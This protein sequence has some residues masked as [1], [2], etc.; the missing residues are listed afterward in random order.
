M[1]AFTVPVTWSHDGNDGTD[2][3]V[4]FVTASHSVTENYLIVFTRKRSQ[5]VNGGFSKP[6]YRIRIIRSFVD[7]DG[8]PLK[9]KAV[10]DTNMSWPVEA[11]A[12]E[13]KAM[14]TLN[15]AIW[16]DTGLDEDI[17]DQQLI[18]LSA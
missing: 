15:G 3:S 8:V 12:S 2:Q 4:F 18:P 11:D 1:A 7:G 14:V 6:S 9:S 16:S 10:I 17:V 5:A 13:V